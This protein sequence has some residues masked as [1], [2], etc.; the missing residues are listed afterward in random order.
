MTIVGLGPR[1]PQILRLLAD[2][3]LDGAIISE[4]HVTIG[5]QA[6]LFNV[7]LGL[8]AL[9]FVPRMQWSIVVANDDVLA[10]RAK[11]R[12]R[13]A[14]RLPAKLSLCRAKPSRMG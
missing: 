1:Y 3:E 6:G 14:A 7:W 10:Q 12:G 8:N 13:G 4:P 9:D 2:G 11:S 5:E